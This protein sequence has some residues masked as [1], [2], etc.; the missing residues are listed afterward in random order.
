M[1]IAYADPPYIGCAH[2]Y[3]DHP[4][5]AGE[6]DHVRLIERLER[7]YDGWI[8]HAAATP[9]SIATLAPLVE[10]TG[11]RWM[12]W[13]KGFAAFKRNIPVAFAWEPVI[14]KA[15]RKPVVSKRLVMRDWIQESITLRRGL[16]G[17]KP[18]AVC[19][20]AFEMVAARPDDTLDDLF[21]GTGAVAQAW[22]TW[23][24]KFALPDEP[25]A[26]SAAP[27]GVQDRAAD[28]AGS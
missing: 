15:A 23:R 16:T 26:R 7:D 21:P 8:L 9:R 11:A 17:A 14:V 2:L 4:D 19:H 10:R 24:L 12:A 22:R 1:K 6:V 13:V 20:W 25:A 5:Y 27:R 28:G 18:E 3:R